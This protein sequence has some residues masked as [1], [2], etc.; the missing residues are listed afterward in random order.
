MGSLNMKLLTLNVIPSDQMHIE[1]NLN[2]SILH[3]VYIDLYF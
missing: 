3:N 1:Y 2:K